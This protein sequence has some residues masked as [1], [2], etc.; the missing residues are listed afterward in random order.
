[1]TYWEA[2]RDPDPA[3]LAEELGWWCTGHAHGFRTER[4]DVRTLA[5]DELPRLIELVDPEVSRWQGWAGLSAAEVEATYRE[6]FAGPM[7]NASHLAVRDGTTGELVGSR[8]YS[9]AYD[10]ASTCETGGWYAANARGKGLGTE[11]MK[12][13]VAFA[14]FHLGFGV[15]RSLTNVDNVAA[16]RQ[17]ERSGLLELLPDGGGPLEVTL[18][19]G[20]TVHGAF[21]EHGTSYASRGCWPAPTGDGPDL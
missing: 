3:A 16:R 18:P 21:Y 15:V 4:L 14:H 7:R 9:T 20:E 19:N 2:F 12:A 6:R 8:T 17:I 13:F 10:T 1:V 11:E 5:P